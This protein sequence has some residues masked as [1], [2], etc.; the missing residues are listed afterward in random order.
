MISTLCLSDLFR[1]GSFPAVNE[2]NF[3]PIVFGIIEPPPRTVVNLIFIWIY[4]MLCIPCSKQYA[5]VGWLLVYPDNYI[6]I[7]NYI[8]FIIFIIFKFKNIKPSMAYT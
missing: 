1:F 8:N 5:H 6:W 7:I 3:L 2:Y 4:L